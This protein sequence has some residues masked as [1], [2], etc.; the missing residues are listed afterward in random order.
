MISFCLIPLT[1]FDQYTRFGNLI[2][3]WSWAPRTTPRSSATH[4]PGSGLISTDALMSKNSKFH[5]KPIVVK[6][7]IIVSNN[8]TAESIFDS[9]EY[10]F[11]CKFGITQILVKYTKNAKMLMTSLF[12]M[13]IRNNNYS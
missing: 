10:Y 8:S 1:A 6:G 2:F 4:A 11:P 5:Q 12:S 13:A 3:L 9:R 7:L